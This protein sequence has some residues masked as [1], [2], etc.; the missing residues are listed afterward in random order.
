MLVGEPPFA[1]ENPLNVYQRILNSTSSLK[2]PNW[3]DRNAK[4]LIKQLLTPDLTKRCG[5]S[6]TG[7][8]DIKEQKWFAEM[9]WHKLLRKEL[10]AP[11]KPKVKSM[12]DT[13]NFDQYPD[14]IEEAATPCYGGG[15]DPFKDF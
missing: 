2:F 7:V 1:D 15:I 4:C 12:H 11:I 13:S 10:E 3:F 8:K 5:C 6:K 14:S 9:D